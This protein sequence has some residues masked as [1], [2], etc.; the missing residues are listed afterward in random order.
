VKIDKNSKLLSLY[1]VTYIAAQRIKGE[2]ENEKKNVCMLAF[3]LGWAFVFVVVVGSSRGVRW[4]KI[5]L[6]MS[7]AQD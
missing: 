6:S 5:I 3:S 4:K 1:V 2:R 7:A